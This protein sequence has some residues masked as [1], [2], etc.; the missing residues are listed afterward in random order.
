VIQHELK[1]SDEQSKKLFIAQQRQ[2]TSLDSLNTLKDLSI[3]LRGKELKQINKIFKIQLKSILT[4]AQLALYKKEEDRRKINLAARAKS[5]K[6][7]VK[8][9]EQ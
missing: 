8:D 9:L 6:I 7:T 1:L 4:N 3:E 5:K 2:M